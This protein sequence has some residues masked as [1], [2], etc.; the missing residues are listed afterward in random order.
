[1][2]IHMNE[3]HDIDIRDITFAKNLLGTQ[4][5]ALK[6]YGFFTSTYCHFMNNVHFFSNTFYAFI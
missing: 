6:L 5:L 2:N 1:M 4:I 3:F